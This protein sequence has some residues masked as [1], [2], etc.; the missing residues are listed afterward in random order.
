L[1]SVSVNLRVISATNKNLKQAIKE[2]QFREDLYYRI[3]TLKINV[4][5]LRER[6]NDILILGNYFLQ[7]HSVQLNKEFVFN[8]PETAQALLSYSWPGNIRQ[9]EGA[10]ERAV[11][12]AEGQEIF[13]VHFG[14]SALSDNNKI[15]LLNTPDCLSTFAEVEQ[16]V[17]EKTLHHFDGNICK[18]AKSLGVSRP[19]VYRKMKSY[20]IDEIDTV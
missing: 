3:C 10:V 13:P 16:N 2:H 15:E 1:K 8:T 18:S 19:T 17:L 6:G 20:G 7:R 14:I 5:S 12:L 11:H 9:L 4:P